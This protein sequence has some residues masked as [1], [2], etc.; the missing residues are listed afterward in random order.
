M[1]QYVKVKCVSLADEAKLIAKYEKQRLRS[2]AVARAQGKKERADYHFAN[3]WG[4]HEH[5]VVDIRKEARIANV[6]YGY[7]NGHPYNKI[8]RNSYTQP[9]W[10]RIRELVRLYG[11]GE[12][13]AKM[14]A[15]DKWELE[16]LA[17]QERLPNGGFKVKG[18]YPADGRH[19]R[20]HSIRL[21]TTWLLRLFQGDYAAF[22]QWF[23]TIHPRREKKPYVRE[24]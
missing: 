4:M 18:S 7:M 9:N 6:A 23:R 19:I 22:T 21:L 5:R 15:Y 12:M 3:Y 14:A 16:A 17:G 24:V 20:P 8:E 1:R 13:D 2:A 10:D 11:E